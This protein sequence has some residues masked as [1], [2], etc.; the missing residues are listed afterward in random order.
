[1]SADQL[2]RLVAALRGIPDL[3]RG[4]CIGL[5][6][7]FDDVA[8]PAPA[9]ALCSQCRCLSNCTEYANSNKKKL[10][11]IVAGMVFDK[12]KQIKGRRQTMASPP[13]QLEIEWK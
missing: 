7:V 12:D 9:Q 13:H 6:D 10:H 11:G 8:D 5:H 2:A 1:M 4:L 3:S